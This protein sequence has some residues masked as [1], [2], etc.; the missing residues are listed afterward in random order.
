MGICRATANSRSVQVVLQT[1]LTSRGRSVLRLTHDP[2]VDANIVMQA[3]AGN[4]NAISFLNS[5]RKL[6]SFGRA[7]RCEFLK[8]G[9]Q[10][11][12][13]RLA[14]HF[15]LEFIDDISYRAVIAEAR[16]LRNAFSGTERRL[17]VMD[18]RQLA[19]A[20]LKGMDFVTNDLLLFK[21]ASDL[22]IP[23]H[24]LDLHPDVG[25]IQSRVAL[26]ADAYNPRPVTIP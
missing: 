17:R 9:T 21:R 11:E 3:Q 16:R 4:R 6:L 25:G 13:N 24:F 22:G 2:V 7:T 19:T 10:A 8:G 5:N 12:L 14:E 20:K 18:S 1:D 15:N 23:V 26:K